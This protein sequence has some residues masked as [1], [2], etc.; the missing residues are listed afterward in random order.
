MVESKAAKVGKVAPLAPP[1]TLL[2]L[3]PSLEYRFV[4]KQPGLRNFGPNPGHQSYQLPPLAIEWLLP[5]LATSSS[6]LMGRCSPEKKKKKMDVS[7]T[8]QMIL[9]KVSNHSL[10]YSIW[11]GERPLVIDIISRKRTKLNLIPH[12]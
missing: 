12:I 9:S 1:A 7:L 4:T 3:V 2:L 5:D 6:A 8:K 11:R 10:D